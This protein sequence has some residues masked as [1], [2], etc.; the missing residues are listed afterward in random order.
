MVLHVVRK[1]IASVVGGRC[2]SGSWAPA[3]LLASLPATVGLGMEVEQSTYGG[4][5][6]QSQDQTRCCAPLTSG[7]TRRRRMCA[8]PKPPG[9]VDC[10][11]VRR[12]HNDNLSRRDNDG[13]NGK[14]AE[15]KGVNNCPCWNC[16]FSLE[17]ASFFCECGAV[18]PLDCHANYF[19]IFD[20]PVSV[21][22][23]PEQLEK[24]FMEMQKIFHPDLF[25][26]KSNKEKEVSSAN[27]TTVNQVYQTLLN[28]MQRV[29][30]LMRLLGLTVLEE[31]SGSRMSPGF[32]AEV[33]ETRERLEE[34]RSVEEAEAIRAEAMAAEG[35]CLQGMEDALRGENMEALE[36]GAVR[37]QYLCRIQEEARRVGH[38]LEDELGRQ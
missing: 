12:V 37:L 36:E 35:E 32:L 5:M 34:C 28:P 38:Q 18:Q 2:S 13:G 23:N 22:V 14:N 9:L 3:R 6:Q 31:D 20:T 16:G 33:M 30:Y 25:G 27:S 26:A 19:E 29:R 4:S 24:K 1:S 7:R 8:P 15:R 17:C 11:G 10:G 21:L